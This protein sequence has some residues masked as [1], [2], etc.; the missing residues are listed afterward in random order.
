M[1]KRQVIFAAAKIAFTA[2]ILTILARKVDMSHVW[3]NLRDAQKAPI[4]AGVLLC[5][6][7]VITAGWRWQRLLRI[8]Q[9]D[10]PVKALISIAQI[11]QFFVMFL[12][13]PTGD[14]LTRM[15]YISRLSLGRVGEACTTVLLARS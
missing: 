3:I 9:I 1:T 4:V 8:F 2:V 5:L 12:P 10:L 11:G 7:T 13:G 14:D 6:G 15:L